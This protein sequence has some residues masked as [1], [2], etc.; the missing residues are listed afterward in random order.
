MRYSHPVI[1]V[2]AVIMHKMFDATTKHL[3]ATDGQLK[4]FLGPC[5]WRNSIFKSTYV[6]SLKSLCQSSKM[7]RRYCWHT[8][9]AWCFLYLFLRSMVCRNQIEENLYPHLWVCE[10]FC[11]KILVQNDGYSLFQA[12]SVTS[13]NDP[14]CQHKH[15][16]LL[17]DLHRK[18]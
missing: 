6:H 2:V 1:V 14:P 17:L 10:Q 4:V 12:R 18:M 13:Q 8:K 11:C 3:S 16:S 5:E 15:W 9:K 7:Y